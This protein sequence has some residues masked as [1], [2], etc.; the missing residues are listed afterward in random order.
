MWKQQNW[1]NYKKSTKPLYSKDPKNKQQKRPHSH[2]PC[3]LKLLLSTPIT[4]K[5]S[6]DTLPCFYSTPVCTLWCLPLKLLKYKDDIT[7]TS[8]WYCLPFCLSV[9]PP[10]RATFQPL[11]HKKPPLLHKSQKQRK[12]EGTKPGQKDLQ[13]PADF[14]LIFIFLCWQFSFCCFRTK[15]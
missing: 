2:A 10:L 5:V 6:A 7:Y 12:K 3:P 11:W 9:C 1:R 14:T 8:L 15:C 4:Y 13:L